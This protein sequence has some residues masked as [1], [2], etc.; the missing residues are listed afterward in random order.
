MGVREMWVQHIFCYK[1]QTRKKT[2]QALPVAAIQATVDHLETT[3]ASAR[4][5]PHRHFSQM[6]CRKAADQPVA[7]L[8]L[9]AVG[10]PVEAVVSCDVLDT[11]FAVVE[12]AEEDDGGRSARTS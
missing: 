5:T 8:L 10:P 1:S 6:I 11:A 12:E 7:A 4:I 3:S 2:R 9:S